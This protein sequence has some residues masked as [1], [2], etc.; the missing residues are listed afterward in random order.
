MTLWNVRAEVVASYLAAAAT[1]LLLI[2]LLPRPH[3]PRLGWP[4]WRGLLGWL[5][6]T[7]ALQVFSFLQYEN[8]LSGYPFGQM[9]AQLLATAMVVLLTRRL[10]GPWSIGAA[11]AP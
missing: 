8:F 7:T 11:L 9:L 6:L 5:A 2:A 1:A 3:R 4:G 10:L